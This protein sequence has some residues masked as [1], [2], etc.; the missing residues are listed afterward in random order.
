ERGVAWVGLDASITRLRL[1]HGRRVLGDAKQLPFRDETFDGVAALYMLYHFDDPLVPV[2]EA[3]RILRPG[4][5]FAACAPGHFDEPELA[6][7]MPPL[8][9][10][11]FDSDMAPG[12][13]GQLFEIAW[14]DSYDCPSIGCPTNKRSG[15]T[16]FPALRTPRS[17]P[18]WRRRPSTHCGL[19][20]VVR[21]FGAERPASV[22]GR[23]TGGYDGGCGILFDMPELPRVLSS[24]TV[25]RGR[26]FNVELDRLA[27]DGGVIAERETLRHPGAVCMIPILQDG[28]LAFVTQYRHP[29]GRRLLELPAGTLEKGE[30]PAAA[31][32]RELQEEIGYRPT[33]C[34]A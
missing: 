30:Q 22:E 18:Q 4:G 3:F 13:L 1:G 19:P 15:T 21:L 10:G 32:V 11:T 33:H 27:M 34:E 5:R 12:L 6:P 9:P 26:L 28:R 24:E 14:I 20:N 25:Y 17:R 23:T 16:W 7:F 2:R 31:A 8:P 29:T